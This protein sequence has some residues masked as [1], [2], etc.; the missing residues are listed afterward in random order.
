ML[1]VVTL[2][3]KVHYIC[4]AELFGGL[5]VWRFRPFADSILWSLEDRA[6]YG[7]DSVLPTDT[8]YDICLEL[9]QLYQMT[10]VLFYFA[11]FSFETIFFL[12]KKRLGKNV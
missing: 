6:A 3:R 2:R 1:R 11:L 4:E 7:H 5:N 12:E 8:A 10:W 9:C